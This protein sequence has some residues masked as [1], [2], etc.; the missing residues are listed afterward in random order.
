M[1]HA[2]INTI[3]TDSFIGA[4]EIIDNRTNTCYTYY[5]DENEY[6]FLPSI[7]EMIIENGLAFHDQPW[8]FRNDIS[9]YD[10]CAKDETEYNHYLENHFEKVQEAVKQPLL[11]LDEKLRE[12]M[13][14]NKDPGEVIDLEEFKKKKSWKPKLI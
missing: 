10:G 3:T 8:W 9:T 11:E 7:E 13:L 14:D 1:L 6:V 5:D 2:K 12:A 4:V